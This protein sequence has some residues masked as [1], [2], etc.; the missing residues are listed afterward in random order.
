MLL[1]SY[2]ATA[3]MRMEQLLAEELRNL[4]AVDVAESRVGA[5]FNGTLETAYKTCLWSRT[6]NRILLP[7]ASFAAETPAALYE[8]VQ[9]V[10]WSDHFGVTQS[11]AVEC[12]SSRSQI[13]HSHFAAL[14]VKDAIADQFRERQGARPSVQ[15]EQPDILINLYLLRDQATLS[16]DL[17]GE[18]LH[19]RGYREQ[20]LGA[21]LKE[22]LAAAMLLRA[23]W[24]EMAARGGALLDPM[25]GSGT[26]PI[27]AVLMAADIAPGLLRRH[28]GFLHW[29]QHDEALWNRLL[30]EAHVRR[31]KGLAQLPVIVGCDQ[32][33]PAVRSAQT[34]AARAGLQGRVRFEQRELS[35]AAP[36]SA[37]VNGL[38]VAN[39]PYGER[40]GRDS[41]LPRLYRLLGDTL[42]QRFTGWQAAILTGTPELGKRLGLRARKIYSLFNGAIECKL[43]CIDI[44]PEWFVND[45]RFPTPLPAE[46][47]SDGAKAFANRLLKNRKHLVRW[48]Q[49]EG[50]S[51][52]R[53]YDADLPEYALAVDV[54]GT[55]PPRVHV[56]EYQAPDSIDPRKAR[57]RLREALG[58][59]LETLEIDEERLYF[60]V[61]KP[62][63]G[64]AQYQ[65]L[66]TSAKFYQVNEGA[67]RLLVNFEDYLDT[68]LFLD[69]RKTRQLLAELAA[70][71]RFLNLFCYTGTASVYAASGGALATTSV[72]MSNTYLDWAQRNM[73]LNRFDGA[74]HRFIR[75][76]CVEWL[77]RGG[78]GNRYGLI[79]LDPPSFSTS[80]RMDA[81][82][83]LQ[84]DHVDLIRGATNLLEPDGVLIFSNNLRRFRMERERLENLEVED[85]SRATLPNDFQ[86]NPRIHNVWRIR[87]K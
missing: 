15:V 5:S 37:A 12:N 86:R 36:V 55:E 9:C 17:S 65:K 1:K 31:E 78:D 77:K 8:G 63:K 71:K 85:I 33:A 6:A 16:L 20:G 21:P 84:R 79:F 68:G 51:C 49:R 26:L 70:G 66:A 76:D 11:F 75:A 40:L 72:D 50:I 59:I 73:Q 67:C 14:K 61:R 38:V 82:L 29:K 13:S 52:F 53:L 18:S 42:K 23:G 45:R 58:V 74:E 30:A 81:T 3:P 35:Q 64:S 41:D 2:I 69:H 7:L 27:E 87:L 47:R 57:L 25:C 44:D 43:L 28:W 48:L 24:P 10:S 56:Q 34:N 54:Y 83:D 4:G 62:Q 80:K 46:S 22:N 32:S 19:R 39:P 60:K